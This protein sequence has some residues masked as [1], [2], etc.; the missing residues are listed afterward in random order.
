[1]VYYMDMDIRLKISQDY[2]NGQSVKDLSKKYDIAASKLYRILAETGVTMRSN[3]ENSR[4]Y[5]LD[6][7]Y[8]S[9]YHNENSY[10]IGVLAADGYIATPKHTSGVISLS[11]K[12]NAENTKWIQQFLDDIGSD[13]PIKTYI[14][15]TAYGDCE[16]IKIRMNSAQIYSDLVNA[17]IVPRKSLILKPPPSKVIARDWIRGYFDGDGSASYGGIGVRLRFCGTEEVLDWIETQLP[18]GKVYWSK[19]YPDS[20]NNY[21]IEV[22]RKS[23]VIDSINYLYNNAT[24]YLPRKRERCESFIRK[25]QT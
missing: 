16:Y 6:E 1:M 12:S 24:R 8:F 3:R 19:R 21:Q 14:N 7:T 17:G 4:K 9:T 20:K 15:K 23:D 22:S 13:A 2:E 11:Q 18:A 10:W 25:Y 5:T